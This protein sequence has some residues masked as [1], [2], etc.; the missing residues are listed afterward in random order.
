MQVSAS[1]DTDA[2]A[3]FASI[4]PKVI[5]AG[6]AFPHEDLRLVL[7]P[8]PLSGDEGDFSPEGFRKPGCATCA[9]VS[10][11]SVRLQLGGLGWFQTPLGCLGPLRVCSWYEP[12]STVAKCATT[13]S[14]VAAEQN[15]IVTPGC[16][17]ENEAAPVGGC[18]SYVYNS[19][20]SRRGTY[21][22]ITTRG[23]TAATP[24]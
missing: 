11:L 24:L 18:S 8:I 7:V 17:C 19:A 6:W 9:R 2:A 22:M 21:N 14:S 1:A 10:L 13:S 4:R 3:R 16:H 23:T 12:Y 5:C 20:G 15:V